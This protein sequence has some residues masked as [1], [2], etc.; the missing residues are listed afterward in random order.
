M[1]VAVG[2]QIE[3]GETVLAAE[4]DKATTEIPSPYTGTVERM[5]TRTR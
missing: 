3:E 4:T 1:N 2:D 5:S